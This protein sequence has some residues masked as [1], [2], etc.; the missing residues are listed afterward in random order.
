VLARDGSKTL[1][2]DTPDLLDVRRLSTADLRAERDRLAALRGACPPDRSRELRLATR[3]H[4]RDL[5]AARERLVL[6]EH[7]LRTTSGQ[8][9]QATERLG[10]LRRDQQRHLGWMEAHDAELRVQ[11]R[12]VGRED[13]WRRRVDQ[14]ALALDP[15]GWL[16]AELG[17]VP[18]DPQERRVWRVAAAELDGYRRA[19]GLDDPGPAKHR[20]AREPREG[21]SARR[22]LRRPWSRPAGA[23]GGRGV[24]AAAPIPI[25]EATAGD[26]CWWRPI[27]G[28]R[29]I[30]SGCWAP[31][32]AGK[33]P[34]AAATGRPPRLRSSAW[35]A[36]AAA[37]TTVTS[38]S[39]T[40]S[41]ANR[42]AVAW[43]TPVAA[44]NATATSWQKGAAHGPAPQP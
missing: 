12:A 4:R 27:G 43:I 23:T 7:G 18:A 31:N 16:V 13:A 37:A 34:A 6:A 8:A 36:G 40:A 3:R 11:E 28:T 20:W 1:A 2:S 29:L 44:R 32:R 5:A 9:E 15:P 14:H 30:L 39:L 41:A 35:P 33:R 19:Y 10:L 25:A 24:T 42:P 21:G 17:P 26:G 38:R 22:P